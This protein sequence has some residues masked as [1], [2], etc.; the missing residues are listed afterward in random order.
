MPD[1]VTYSLEAYV[2][3]LRRIAAATSDCG[4]IFDQVAPLARRLALAKKAWLKPNHYQADPDQG[5]GVHLLH[6][7]ADHTL[8]VFAVAWLPHDGAPPHDHGTWAVI[9]GV[10]GVERNV[11]Y[12]RLDDRSRPDYA[13]LEERCS[14]EAGEGDIV[15]IR[16][17][18]IHSVWNDTD[19][20]T[21]SLHTYGRHVGYTDRS[22][23]DLRTNQI[24]PFVILIN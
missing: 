16:P 11:K 2:V 10:D 22:A 4:R 5:F 21:V 18:G 20:V 13:A 8:A 19:R 1:D 12:N 17:K 9:A 14:I 23:F 6:E 3:D 7:E 15:C 24:S